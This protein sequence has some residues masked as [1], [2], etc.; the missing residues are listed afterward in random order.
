LDVN[1]N[2]L[3]NALTIASMAAAA[4]KPVTNGQTW[5]RK[6]S[7]SEWATLSDDQA[8]ARNPFSFWAPLDAY[9]TQT[10]ENLA[11]YT[12]MTFVDVYLSVYYWAYLPYD[13]STSAMTPSQIMN[14]ETQQS[15]RNMS[16]ASFTSTAQSYYSSIL[17][18]PDTTPPS[19]PSNLTGASGAPT[20]AYLTWNA[21]TDNVGVAGY[22]VFRNGVNVGTT[23][24]ASYTDTGLTDATTYSYFVE[25]FDLAGNV[26]APSLTAQVTTWNN[27]PPSTPTRVVGTAVSCQQINL[28]WSASTGKIAIAGYYVFRGTS[29]NNLT[30]AGITGGGTSYTNYPLTPATMYYFGVEAIDADGNV[31][32]M[33]AIVSA[34]TLALPS[35]PAKL[36]ATPASTAQIGLTWSAGPSGMPIAAYYIFRGPTPSNL[37]RV[38]IANST[39][40]S[41]TNYS[42]IPSTTYYYGVEA[43]DTGGNVSPMSAIVSGTTLALPSPPASVTGTAISSV[44]IKVTWTAAQSGM[45]LAYYRVS[46]GS[47]P[48]NLTQL[49][50]LSPTT[51][52][53]TNYPVTSGT[54]YYYGIQ[55][56]DTGGNVSPMSAVVKVTTPN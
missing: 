43:L 22:Y 12:H 28:T 50:A 35:A 37:T 56:A 41:Y 49:I 2:C 11:Y 39:P 4:G 29:A 23:A 54:T 10:M 52:S 25:A 42:L 17:P 31:S 6:V 13:L 44:Q 9:F 8:L 27:I 15:S 1:Y 51:T 16:V 53:F 26:S 36:A 30:R 5:L 46:R 55:S 47:S 24:M 18:A 45:P 7:N 20:Q 3:P 14:Q 40:T 48:S 38:G 19:T 21:S 32:P 34:T 33:S